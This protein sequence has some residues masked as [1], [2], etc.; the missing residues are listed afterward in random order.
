[1]L[2]PAGSLVAK[3]VEFCGVTESESSSL[4]V[5]RDRLQSLLDMPYRS[6]PLT[7]NHKQH[8]LQGVVVAGAHAGEAAAT[9]KSREGRASRQAAS[10]RHILHV[11]VHCTCMTCNHT[12]TWCRRSSG[13]RRRRSWPHGAAQAKRRE[14]CSVDSVS[15]QAE[16]RVLTSLSIFNTQTY[17]AEAHL[18]GQE[19]EAADGEEGRGGAAVGGA[20]FVGHE[21]GLFAVPLALGQ[22]GKLGTA[23][24]VMLLHACVAYL[25]TMAG[26]RAACGETARRTERCW[27]FCWLPQSRLRLPAQQ[28]D[29]WAA[30]LGERS[31]A[32]TQPLTGEGLNCSAGA[33]RV[34]ER[35]TLLSLLGAN[36]RGQTSPCLA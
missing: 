12:L 10:H 36:L 4:G 3:M 7:H 18:V 34:Q 30:V 20:G 17:K 8:L 24:V 5:V 33:A 22:P 11:T 21:R 1:M 6:A 32:E 25:I 31:L 27:P 35:S 14:G 28:K 16:L 26:S 19:D 13:P 2:K 9:R 15:S 23:I 29:S